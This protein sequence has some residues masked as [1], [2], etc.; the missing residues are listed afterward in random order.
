MLAKEI[1]A[2]RV[3]YCPFPLD[4]RDE[5]LCV[6]V[7]SPFEKCIP[8]GVYTNKYIKLVFWQTLF[9]QY[10]RQGIKS[11][12]IT[13][14]SWKGR[15]NQDIQLVCRGFCNVNCRPTASNYQLF[16]LRSCWEPNPDLRSGR[17]ECY[18]SATVAPA[19]LM[20]E[21]LLSYL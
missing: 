2:A 13:M 15:G 7:A 10:E 21:S 20:W 9:H 4:L 5:F 8:Q 17:Q 1:K 11:H 19:F 3:H 18:H 14:G 16:Y 12:C 6:I